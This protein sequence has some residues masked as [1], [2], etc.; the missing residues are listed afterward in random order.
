MFN[1]QKKIIL[2]FCNQINFSSFSERN[3]L[4]SQF[5]NLKEK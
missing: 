1:I 5:K 2:I 4:F 3:D